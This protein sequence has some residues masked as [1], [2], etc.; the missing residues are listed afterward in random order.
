MAQFDEK[1][2][3]VLQ[4]REIPFFPRQLFWVLFHWAVVVHSY[5]LVELPIGFLPVPFHPSAHALLPGEQVENQQNGILQ[6]GSVKALGLLIP[7]GELFDAAGQ[8]FDGE[9][10]V[11]E[12]LLPVVVLHHVQVAEVD[13]LDALE[14]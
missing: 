10:D 14:G 6:E 1:T 12:L 8:L 13:V 3:N 9:G 11:L 4:D 2:F 5:F 7:E